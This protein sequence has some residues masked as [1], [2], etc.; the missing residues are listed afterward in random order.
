MK[1]KAS[2]RLKKGGQGIGTTGITRLL[3]VTLLSGF[4]G[5]GK[6]T[7]LKRILEGS[8]GRKIAVIVNDMAALNIDAKLI[9][10]SGLVQVQQEVVQMENGCICCVI[11]E[12]LVRE[13]RKICDSGKYEYLVIES[14]GISEPMQ[15]AEA[16]EMEESKG[17][18]DLSSMAYLDTCV[19]VIDT[20]D[21]QNYGTSIQSVR[22]RFAEEENGDKPIAELL[23]NQIECANVIL[24]NKAD[25]SSPDQIKYAEDIVKQLNP[26]AMVYKTSRS[27]V[28][29]ANIIQ[30]S[31]FNMEEMKSRSMI[32]KSALTESHE[33]GLDH[34]IFKARKPFHPGRLF[35]FI[36]RYYILDDSLEILK[37]NAQSLVEERYT[38]LITDLGAVFR[39]KGI[40]WIAG[41][42]DPIRIEFVQHGRV[43]K[44]SP[45]GSWLSESPGWEQR[46]HPDAVDEI[47]RDEFEDGTD[48]RQEIVIIGSNVRYKKMKE[49]LSAVLVTDTELESID[50]NISFRL[51]LPDPLPQWRRTLGEGFFSLTMNPLN[52]NRCCRIMGGYQITIQQLSFDLSVNLLS[53]SSG[54]WVILKV[55]AMLGKH[56]RLITTI[57]TAHFGSYQQALSLTFT[58]I[59]YEDLDIDFMLEVPAASGDNFREVLN[60]S[61]ITCF[62][63]GLS[64]SEAPKN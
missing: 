24:L 62:V 51:S 14:T 36:N 11:R 39:M 28:D 50:S 25:I 20:F 30:T 26:T 56:P 6:T 33:Y 4:L 40:I 41:D 45:K 13:I 55:W 32:G 58:T 64:Q 47:M 34:T 61:S 12:D 48:K 1:K 42:R 31:M 15:V 21:F 53:G 27:R 52:D 16:F 8:H 18:S 3:P 57:N 35:D 29:L 23:I 54:D 60:R 46:M 19:T 22:E 44:L 17:A 59:E 5:A 9:K 10:S 38:R 49:M 63:Y 2:A 37:G 43:V 7:L